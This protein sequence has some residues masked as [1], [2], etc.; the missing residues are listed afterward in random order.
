MRG[1]VF[2][3]LVFSSAHSVFALEPIK[4]KNV[5]SQEEIAS[6]IADNNFFFYKDLDE[7]TPIWVK[8][9]RKY[10]DHF[11]GSRKFKLSLPEVIHKSLVNGFPVQTQLE[12]IYQA[13]M[14]FHQS[15]GDVVPHLNLEFGQG[16][17]VGIE[18][19]FSGLFGFLLPSHWMN[20]VNKK[21]IHKISRHYLSLNVFDQVL[22][23]KIAYLDQHQLIQKFET[24]N[25]YFLHLQLLSKQ[26]KLN[27]DENHMIHGSYSLLGTR[28][29]TN[30]GDIKFGFNKLALLMGMEAD[31]RDRTAGRLNIRNLVNFPNEVKTPDQLKGVLRSKKDFLEEVV[32]RSPELKIVKELYKVSK[33][34]IGIK[35]FG[36]TLSNAED[37]SQ[38]DDARFAINLGYGTLPGILESV[39]EQRSARIDVR[40]EYINILNKA[41]DSYDHYTNGLGGFTEAK[42][43]LQVN[44]KIFKYNVKSYLEGN[45]SSNGIRILITLNFLIETENAYNNALHNALRGKAYMDRFLL[46]GSDDYFKYLPQQKEILKSFEESKIKFNKKKLRTEKFDELFKEVLSAKKLKKLLYGISEDD[47]KFFSSGKKQEELKEAV[48]INLDLLLKSRVSLFKRRKKDFYR[49]LEKYIIQNSL[50][51]TSEQRYKL[52][53]KL[54]RSI[55]SLAGS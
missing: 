7:T 28:M 3:L 26:V 17:S 23:A 18:R 22:K 6:I 25:Y 20:I 2:F 32:K 33:L 19:V 47:D 44:R 49:V 15:I 4:P 48:Q 34:N 43:A 54:K 12:K 31:D 27:F 13:K 29:A 35:S 55:D 50:N 30:R 10:S 9:K 24:I 41:R 36:G 51:M 40:Q 14:N 16:L 38:R 45:D 11:L 52:N 37:G 8:A 1:L 39:S 21:R 5:F 46:T 42:R 53:R